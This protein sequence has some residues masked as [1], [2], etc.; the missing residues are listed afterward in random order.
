MLSTMIVLAG[1]L[2]PG[3]QQKPGPEAAQLDQQLLQGT[4]EEQRKALDGVLAHAST[5]SSVHL[6]EASL[7]AF[8]LGRLEDAGFLF[9]AGKLRAHI[10]QECFPPVGQGGDSPGVALTAVSYQIGGALNPA[11]MREPKSYKAAIER[12]RA[13]DVQMPRGYDPGWEYANPKPAAEAR[14][15][16]AKAKGEYLRPAEGLSTLLNTP[17]YFE[18]FKIVQDYNF[19]DFKEKQKPEARERMERAQKS[20]RAIEE[21]MGIEGLFYKKGQVAAPTPAPPTPASPTAPAAPG[22]PSRAQAITQL[23]ALGYPNPNSV[24]NFVGAAGTGR[25]DVVKLYLEAGMP[26]DAP[27]STGYRAFL[28]ALISGRF[29]VARILLEAGADVNAGDEKGYLTPLIALSKYC[30]QKDLLADMI[31]A[32]ARV[33]VTT[34]GGLTALLQANV[35]GCTDFVRMLKKAGATR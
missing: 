29:G 16:V 12:L 4:I 3:P 20:L 32:G 2:S 21:R 10:D 15:L 23:K 26:V 8:R 25:E 22:A 31:K 18:A 35:A 24:E 34:R 13:W 5:T 6:L 1:L 30:D 11:I 7:A 19:S 9:F 17:E 27:I 28:T 33:N 14:A